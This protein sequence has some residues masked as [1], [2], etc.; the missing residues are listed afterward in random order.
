MLVAVWLQNVGNSTS[1][2]SNE[3]PS[4]PGIRAVRISISTESNGSLP[5]CV[6]WRGTPMR[7]SSLPSSTEFS[8]R[9]SSLIAMPVAS[10][11]VAFYRTLVRFATRLAGFLRPS[12]SASSRSNSSTS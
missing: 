11:S 3:G 8:V 4:L 1:R 6:K 12:S 10:S 7:T 9:F 2:C 5:G